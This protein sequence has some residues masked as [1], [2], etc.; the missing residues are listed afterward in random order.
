MSSTITNLQ[1]LCEGKIEEAFQIAEKHYNV[2]LERI[3]IMFCR[4]KQT[5]AGLTYFECRRSKIVPGYIELSSKL[6][7]LNTNE[8]INVIPF[9]EA[10][11][12]IAGYIYKHYDHGQPWGE[13]MQVLGLKNDQFHTLQT[14][15]GYRFLYNTTAGY[16]V[17]ISRRQHCMIQN[18]AILT[19]GEGDDLLAEN[20]IKAA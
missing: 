8:F 5:T 16:Q 4:R 18:G 11:H 19:Y 9:H 14:V 1:A 17:E 20:F 3:P 10:A 13:V 15:P 7:E 2:T 6:L 12:A